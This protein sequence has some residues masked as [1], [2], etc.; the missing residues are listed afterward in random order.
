MT[1]F[2]PDGQPATI[3]DPPVPI[4]CGENGAIFSMRWL[5]GAETTF[6]S[7]VGDGNYGT[8]TQLAE[9]G[10]INA[11]LANGENCGYI[12]R[13]QVTVRSNE[14]PARF[15]IR[16]VPRQYGVTGFRSFFVDE[17]GIIRGADK[18]GAE[19]NADDPPIE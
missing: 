14:T 13:V 11:Y 19:A 9:A 16:S 15:E 18:G 12:F 10:L 8:L 3:N 1:L 6:Q 2:S 4:Y 7:T 17:S 5:H